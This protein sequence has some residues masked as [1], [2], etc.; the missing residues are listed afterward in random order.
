[1]VPLESPAHRRGCI[2]RCVT[3]DL[4]DTKSLRSISM[5]T[6]SVAT[7]T[8]SSVRYAKYQRERERHTHINHSMHDEE[9]DV[10]REDDLDAFFDAD[11]HNMSLSA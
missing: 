2:L 4:G 10:C 7:S 5:S 3:N 9:M 8:R 6:K 11:Q 1:M